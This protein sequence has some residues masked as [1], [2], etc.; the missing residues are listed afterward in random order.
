MTSMSNTNNTSMSMNA[1]TMTR[2]QLL[3]AMKNIQVQGS[4]A[5][6]LLTEE[7]QGKSGIA[8]ANI[9][10]VCDTVEYWVCLHPV[11]W[12]ILI[13][14]N[15][16]GCLIADS[17]A[18]PNISLKGI[19]S[20]GNIEVTVSFA[21]EDVDAFYAATPQ[22]M[23]ELLARLEEMLEYGASEEE[24]SNFRAHIQ[25]VRDYT[26]WYNKEMRGI[27]TDIDGYKETFRRVSLETGKKSVPTIAKRFKTLFSPM[28]AIYGAELERPVNALILTG[29]MG[30][31]KAVSVGQYENLHVGDLDTYMQV[32]DGLNLIS[33]SMASRLAD[34]D[35]ATRHGASKN[36]PVAL[37]EFKSYTGRMYVKSGFIK[38]QFLVVPDALMT[39]LLPDGARVAYDIIASEMKSEMS[40]PE[41]QENNILLSATMK[42]AAAK[43]DVNMDAQKLLVHLNPETFEFHNLTWPL[44]MAAN[45]QHFQ[46]QIEKVLSC[47]GVED[48]VEIFGDT[49][50]DFDNLSQVTVALALAN[51]GVDLRSIPASYASIANECVEG[52]FEIDRVRVPLKT[53]RNGKVVSTAFTGYPI[54][55]IGP[56][57][58][59]ICIV[60]D[61]DMPYEYR[62]GNSN[63][64]TRVFLDWKPESSTCYVGEKL[65]ADIAP[66][67]SCTSLSTAVTRRP[68]SP[69]SVCMLTVE[70]L[71]SY[72]P[73]EMSKTIWTEMS[74]DMFETLWVKN[75]GGDLDDKFEFLVGDFAPLSEAF[76][77]QKHR[78][79][80]DG[81]RNAW[82]TRPVFATPAPGDAFS[83]QYAMGVY[84][85]LEKQYEAALKKFFAMVEEGNV[86]TVKFTLDPESHCTPMASYSN[87]CEGWTGQ[88]ANFSMWLLMVH[89]GIVKLQCDPAYSEE[90]AS[91]IRHGLSVM[92]SDVVDAEVQNKNIAKAAY[93]MA[94]F[95]YISWRLW[96]IAF[97]SRNM[98]YS[99]PV[100]KMPAASA[101]RMAFTLKRAARTVYEDVVSMKPKVA[102]INS[103]TVANVC[104]GMLLVETPWH[105][106]H[107]MQQQYVDR[108]V[109]HVV[110]EIQSAVCSPDLEIIR[111]YANSLKLKFA[112]SYFADVNAPAVVARTAWV[113]TQAAIA[114]ERTEIRAKYEHISH[115][116]TRDTLVKN[117]SSSVYKKHVV[118]WVQEN[119]AYFTDNDR[120]ALVCMCLEAVANAKVMRNTI[121][122]AK[123]KRFSSS[124][125]LWGLLTLDD[126]QVDTDTVV[127]GLFRDTLLVLS[128]LDMNAE[129]KV[130]MAC[131]A[132]A[133][134]EVNR[135]A[136]FTTLAD[137]EKFASKFEGKRFSDVMRH[138]GGMK[139]MTLDTKNAIAGHATTRGEVFANVLKNMPSSRNDNGWSCM[140]S[141][142][143][144]Q[145]NTYNHIMSCDNMSGGVASLM[146]AIVVGVRVVAVNSAGRAKG[147]K[148]N[149]P[150]A[151]HDQVS[152]YVSRL[153][154]CVLFTGKIGER[155]ASKAMSVSIADTDTIVKAFAN[156]KTLEISKS[157]DAAL[158]VADV[159][160][161]IG[162]DLGLSVV[163]SKMVCV[164]T[165]YYDSKAA[166]RVFAHVPSTSEKT[167]IV[168]VSE[169][170]NYKEAI[171]NG[172]LVHYMT[173]YESL[174]IP[175]NSVW[176]VGVYDATGKTHLYNI[177]V[178]KAWNRR[179]YDI[180]DCEVYDEN[181]HAHDV[182][183]APPEAPVDAFLCTWEY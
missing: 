63:Y 77:A 130:Y 169:S 72:L 82:E 178:V 182:G 27:F 11:L 172:D 121:Y 81:D 105:V 173:G 43:D 129:R 125:G 164:G 94:T 115:D 133:A 41:M 179:F 93:A 142:Q 34:G 153:G 30:S 62:C 67:A 73:R 88:A 120:I 4:A 155:A 25:L 126:I 7:C 149:N 17:A 168:G 33:Y 124:S 144:Q 181:D 107:T 150:N 8:F 44:I 92:L 15:R 32:I 78:F 132:N 6:M 45:V 37:K 122:D 65:F 102:K 118:R 18:N 154:W 180:S 85:G 58:C 106:T 68:A 167:K 31:N 12:S 55:H 162:D 135:N 160:S 139:A 38:G 163:L 14:D 80:A 29:Y 170:C 66:N 22:Y 2:E 100:M 84:K 26:A 146:D 20:E 89:H 96:W 50:K 56:L 161:R 86:G 148:E 143:R 10:Y 136:V 79:T 177:N 140:T 46:E 114:A 156:H 13:H 48:Y 108:C 119:L 101:S 39:F 128:G 110:H 21:Y 113:E 19:D 49:D 1:A 123:T 116:E 3:D 87:P 71:P 95:E 76:L 171:T 52:D 137:A 117:E 70:M 99:K 175:V 5:V 166:A 57:L 151:T 112:P 60:L 159:T 59:D 183:E 98:K 127:R 61:A 103:N 158:T 97:M 174:V 176:C 64:K 69:G 111:E 42:A 54:P 36:W 75:D 104:K 134:Y 28:R 23:Q 51:K 40:F 141:H 16:F 91:L 47:E 152:A 74:R 157:D 165:S 131:N 9:H 35:G 53:L 138:V 90:Q 145:V 83:N 147:Y 109:G 24:E